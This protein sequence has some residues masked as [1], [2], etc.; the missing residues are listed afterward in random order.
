VIVISATPDKRAPTRRYRRADSLV[1]SALGGDT[2]QA[3]SVGFR[4]GQGLAALLGSADL[5]SWPGP[6]WRR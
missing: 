2:E 1:R 5:L 4:I 3:G 6:A